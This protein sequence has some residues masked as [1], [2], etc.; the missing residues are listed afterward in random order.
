MAK[1]TT[2]YGPNLG[3]IA[4]EASVAGSLDSSG[5]SAKAFTDA[6]K[7]GLAIGVLE[8]KKRDLTINAYVDSIGSVA[9]ISKISDGT[10]KQQITD[11]VRGQR[12][13]AAE[14]AKHLAQN[15]DDREAKDKLEAIKTSFSNLNTQLNDFSTEQAEYLETEDLADSS[16][17]DSN[18]FTNAF[19]NNGM[20]TIDENGNIG[21]TIDDSNYLYK[22]KKNQWSTK[23]YTTQKL[24]STNYVSQKKLGKDG[25]DFDRNNVKNGI[26]NHFKGTGTD[27]DIG[28]DGLQQMATQDLT[29][30]NDYVLEDG[31]VA[32]NMSFREMWAGGHLDDKF[33]DFID[34]E[35]LWED[36]SYVNP[37]LSAD[38]D[39]NADWMMDDANKDRL[40][41]LMAE[42]YTDV[43]EDGHAGGAALYKEPEETRSSSRRNT[44]PYSEEVVDETNTETRVDNSPDGQW[45]SWATDSLKVK[46][47]D[48]AWIVDNIWEPNT[49]TGGTVQLPGENGRALVQHLESIRGYH[50]AK[51]RELGGKFES[52]GEYVTIT[53]P[54]G[55]EE[56]WG[57]DS[58]GGGWA[59]NADKNDISEILVALKLKKDPAATDYYNQIEE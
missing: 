33:Y 57:G 36:D 45:T 34:E 11:F 50:I 8:N 12:D 55:E 35:N 43:M 17:F 5:A 46:T 42:Y 14:I 21:H 23:N 2:S 40:A 41:E 3:L 13:K 25:E 26:V 37:G 47:T 18:Y 15:P 28:V 31:T 54:G 27:D 38:E 53:Q 39:L 48:E 1:K 58:W 32:G 56:S 4:G 10:N 49:P 59:G 7:S 52:D 9:N 51:F 29:E 19:T 20:F 44:T 6:F 30:D 24:L 16:V 22:D